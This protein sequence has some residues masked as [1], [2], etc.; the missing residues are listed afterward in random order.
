MQPIYK[1]ARRKTTNNPTI[2]IISLKK[3]SPSIT[4]NLSQ[5]SRAK[6]KA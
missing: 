4:R 3:K 6:L 1:K 5:D 2:K